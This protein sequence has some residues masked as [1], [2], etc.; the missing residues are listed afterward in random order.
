MKEDVTNSTHE[1]VQR[2]YGETLQSS[3]D[4][5]TSAC[6]TSAS[7]EGHV[8]EALTLIHPEVQ[9][10]YYGCGLALPEALDGLRVLD[11]GCGAGRDV[12]LLSK[13]VGEQGSVVGVDMTPAQLEIARTHQAFHADAFG[14]AESNVEFLEGNIERLDELGLADGSFD[15]II[16]NCV[17]NLAVDKLAVLRS[18]HRLL[19]PGGEMYFSDI[20]ADRRIPA[21]LKEDPV[22]YGECLSGAL[23]WNDFYGL[24]AAAGFAAPRLVESEQLSIDDEAVAVKTGEIRFCSATFRL[25]SL[26]DAE[27]AA[28]NYGQQAV[29]RGTVAESPDALRLDQHFRFEAGTPT[30]VCGNTARIIEQS[31]FSA[32]FDILGS[33]CCHLGAF[34]GIY[35]NDV[36][37]NPATKA[38]SGGCC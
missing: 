21:A 24:A 18:A 2:Y 23:Y 25:F 35:Q 8:R 14:H 9:S 6:C 11:L 27:S 20:Y 34:E 4:L 33:R 7:P 13:L 26:H 38:A 19:R 16:S 36:F 30:P 32:H 12:Y 5:K 15:L 3:D 10:R 29:Y 31:R 17:I 1:E 22:L 28:E 37:A